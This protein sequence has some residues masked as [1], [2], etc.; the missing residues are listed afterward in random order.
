MPP[1]P[2]Q[3]S[4]ANVSAHAAVNFPRRPN[5][6]ASV[7]T[8][9][10]Q[11]HQLPT[12]VKDS[13]VTVH[14]RNLYFTMKGS[15]WQ[16]V[17]LIDNKI[18]NWQCTNVSEYSCI[19]HRNLNINSIRLRTPMASMHYKW[20]PA[21]LPLNSSF[22]YILYATNWLRKIPL[23]RFGATSCLNLV[24]WV[25]WVPYDNDDDDNKSAQSKLGTGSRRGPLW[26]SGLP[27]RLKDT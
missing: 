4:T 8:L 10:Y 20:T 12:A 22:N 3:R 6:S 24:V 25:I 21:Y 18:H 13:F 17:H 26:G 27:S 16:N 7:R 11:P 14:I 19:T 15:K 23:Q 9:L 1:P 5:L 2:I